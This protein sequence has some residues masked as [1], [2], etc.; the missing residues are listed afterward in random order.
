MDDVFQFANV[1]R[2]VVAGQAPARL[3]AERHL[4]VTEAAAVFGDEVAGQR[5][6]VAGSLA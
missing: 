5:Q 4:G 3:V 2:P 1:S 6:D